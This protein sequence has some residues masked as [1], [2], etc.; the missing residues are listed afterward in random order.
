MGAP[1]SSLPRL[2]RGAALPGI[3]LVVL[4][5]LLSGCGREL[6]K[7]KVGVE[8]TKSGNSTVEVRITG[9]TRSL[10]LAAPRRTATS[11]IHT[12]TARATTAQSRTESRPANHSRLAPPSSTREATSPRRTDWTTVAAAA[13]RPRTT[14]Q[15]RGP[16]AS[17]AFNTARPSIGRIVRPEGPLRAP[18]RRLIRA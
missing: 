8:A 16:L 10:A 11:R 7:G 14:A 5:A 3:L 6:I 1:D 17:P 18:S 12:K 4:V 15:R 9:R 2:A 13:T